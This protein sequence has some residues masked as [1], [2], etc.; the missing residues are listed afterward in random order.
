MLGDVGNGMGVGK[1]ISDRV[2]NSLKKQVM[3]LVKLNT[4]FGTGSHREAEAS[5]L[6]WVLCSSGHRCPGC[7]CAPGSPEGSVS[8]SC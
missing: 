7:G 5:L 3:Y 1:G 6:F 2:N 4:T 8:F